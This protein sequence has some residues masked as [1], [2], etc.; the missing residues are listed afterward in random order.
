M[1]V[2]TL[3][4]RGSSRSE[5]IVPSTLRQLNAWGK[6]DGVVLKFERTAGDE[7][8]GTLDS[9]QA[10]VDVVTATVRTD[11]WR[12]G[13]GVGDVE[14]PLPRSTRAARGTAYVAARA[15]I[16][17][18]RTSPQHLSV[19]GAPGYGDL[20][21][22]SFNRAITNAESA[23][24]LLTSLL[25]RR[26]RDGW[27]VVHLADTG[28]TQRQVAEQLGVSASAVSQRL[29]RAGHLEER[30]GRALASALLHMAEVS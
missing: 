25:R 7:V 9:Q 1:Y 15:A 6:R 20:D 27:Q 16:E 11:V 2:M 3:D 30:R 24:W 8:Q 10:V 23:L 21:M 5:D 29:R 22:L 4:Q 14:L 12:I 17:A 19:V 26:T 28:V 18:A 13:I